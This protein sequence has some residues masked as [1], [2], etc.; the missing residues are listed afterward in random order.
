MFQKNLKKWFKV[1]I[2]GLIIVG[3]GLTVLVWSSNY[4]V[5]TTAQGKI[6]SV[7]MV[8]EAPAALVLGAGVSGKHRVS[9]IFQERLDK[10]VELYESGKV[11][12]ILVS[13]DNGQEDYDE[14]TAAK[15]YLITEKKI[16]PQ[17]IFLDHAGF[18]TYDSLYRAR[19]VFVADSYIIVTQAFHLPRAL[20]IA[21]NL[22]LKVQGVSAGSETN[23]QDGESWAN[24]EI[25]ANVKATA[26]V[27]M[28]TK[29]KYLGKQFPLTGDGRETWT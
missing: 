6:V 14:V 15:N 28:K 29:P 24:R 16:P 12:K 4:V 13:G 22:G 26:D 2:I 27:L 8:N 17:D 10:A 7:Q 3:V 11:K 19:E 18:D 5:W 9:W 25:L 20:Y 21:Q 23:Y 1:G